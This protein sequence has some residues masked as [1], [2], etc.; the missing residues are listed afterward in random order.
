MKESRSIFLLLLLTSLVVCWSAVPAE[1]ACENGLIFGGAIRFR[2]EFQDNFSQKYYGNNPARGSSD[3]GFLLGRFRA[4]LDYRPS[5]K[6]HLSLWMQNSEVWDIALPDSAFYTAT[7]AKEHN[8]NKDRWE[9]WDTYLEVKELFGLP[10]T[11]K[12]GRQRIFYGDNRIFGPGEWGNDGRWIWDAAKVSY[13]FSGG[14][15]DAYYGRT[16]LHEPGEFSLNHRHGFE[17][18]GIYGHVELPERFISLAVEPFFITKVDDHD[19]YTGG[20]G[21][22]GDL[23]SYYLG[24]RSCMKAYKGFDYDLTFISQQGDFSGDDIE[25]YGYHIL[26]GYQFTG[27]FFKPRVSIEYS[28]ASGDDDRPDD[29][30]ETFDGAFGARDKLYGR[31]NLFYWQNLKD[32]QINLE[33]KPRKWIYIKVELHKFWLAERNDAWY[34]N[35]RLYRDPSGNSGNQLGREFDIVARLDFPKSNQIQL[36]YGHF[37]PDEFVKK[38]ASSKEADWI[39][40][41]WVYSFSLKLI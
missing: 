39:F 4:G 7:F 41:Q 18:F 13:S 15:L 9:F 2:Y 22:K 25:A 12:G 40:L 21:A 31:L 30:Y 8:P 3:D 36:G 38:Q 27:L 14:F 16:Q 37:W 35:K 28:Y 17:S 32:A 6:I 5:Q 29:E 34:L 26:L 11:V 23:D 19:R 33:V 1:S 20:D 24:L 10:L